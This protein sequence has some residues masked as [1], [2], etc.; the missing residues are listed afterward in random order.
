MID[1]GIDG[2]FRQHYFGAAVLPDSSEYLAV[3]IRAGYR[4]ASTFRPAWQPDAP[5]RLVVRGP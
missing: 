5:L 4:V 2:L 1:T 3:A